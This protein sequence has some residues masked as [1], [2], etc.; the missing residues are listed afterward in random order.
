MEAYGKRYAKIQKKLLKGTAKYLD[1][2]LQQAMVNDVKKQMKELGL[3]YEELMKKT[4]KAASKAQE[5]NT[6]WARTTKN[7]QKIK[8]WLI[9]NGIA[10]SGI[11]KRVS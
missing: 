2:Q 1:P 5:V 9:R 4:T 11:P 7:Q 3:S 8:R 6:M 10:L